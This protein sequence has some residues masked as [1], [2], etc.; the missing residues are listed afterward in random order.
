M[1]EI[2]S[3]GVVTATGNLEKFSE[4]AKKAESSSSSLNDVFSQISP[5]ALM[6][7]AGVL[8]LYKAFSSL[9]SS[10][11]NF[12]KSSISTY[13]SFE[14]IESG[15]QGVM[16]SAEKGSAMFERLRAFSF[17]TTFG[18]DTL[19]NAS[20]Q[21]LN[22]GV[23]AEDLETK[24]LQ[25]GNV[26]GGDTNKF[27]ELVSIYAKINNT[28]KAG[29]EQLQQLALRQVPIYQ[30]L[31][32]IGV[33][34][35]A[36][37]D[38]VSKAFELMTAKGEQFNGAMDRINKTISG[39]EGFVSDT[40]REFLTSFAEASGLADTYKSILDVVK[41]SLQ[42]V[43]D[44]LA[45][46]NANPVYQ[47]IFRGVL[48]GTLTAIVGI[49]GVTLVKALTAVIVKLGIIVALK[50]ALDPTT[51]IAVAIGGIAGITAGLV[52][53]QNKN[54]DMANS[55]D[56][57]ADSIEHAR[58]S[59]ENYNKY[60]SSGDLETYASDEIKNYT[61]ELSDL[62]EQKKQLQTYLNGKTGLGKQ[63]MQFG[64]GYKNLTYQSSDGKKHSL[65]KGSVEEY[66]EAIKETKATID[67][68]NRV[69]DEI[70]KKKQGKSLLDSMW[71]SVV[72]DD[73]SKKIN[74]YQTKI[75]TLKEYKKGFISDTDKGLILDNGKTLADYFTLSEE[76]KNKVNDTI[77]YIEKLKNGLHTG[78]E[79]I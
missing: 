27:N 8:S 70:D 76:D 52:S 18:V 22:V 5:T 77:E 23:S 14:Q 20:T 37:A 34:G 61:Q 50:S 45:K 62:T 3:N 67:E 38:D 54:K 46:I 9:I 39:K 7:S 28:G 36:T 15:L 66:D 21:L 57:V 40:W 60:A 16:K 19:A 74:D 75:D 47:A 26:A 59:Q 32:K 72:G 49:I 6:A 53:I 48:V 68:I 13:S 2:D 12:S 63:A 1:L 58:E 69:Q 56:T 43:V 44:W 17:D 10:V 11:S 65:E 24:L 25:L 29:A 30:Y 55:Y 4:K 64:G 71:N 35:T 78:I 79:V 51:L 41:E 73:V 31:K 33:Q 42:N